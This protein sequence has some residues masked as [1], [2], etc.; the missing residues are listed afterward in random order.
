MAQIA[1]LDL[2]AS[3]LGAHSWPIE[4][5]WCFVGGGV[6]S[7][8]IAPADSWPRDAWNAEA[9]A[10]HGISMDDLTMHGQTIG[11]VCHQLNEALSGVE[12]Y[13]DAPD[14]DGFWL[15][16][17]FSTGGVRQMFELKDFV[18]AVG[19]PPAADLRDAA[20]HI[21][22]DFPYSH[23]TTPDVLH[24]RAIYDYLQRS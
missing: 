22:S 16:R 9:A 3:G 18:D 15:Y 6:Q 8:L 20:A 23:R 1:F 11:R 24:M 21:S 17:L 19:Q 14:W 13:S 4:V 5:G 2:E 10:L 7:V 12:V